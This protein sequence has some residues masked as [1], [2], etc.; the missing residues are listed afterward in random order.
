MNSLNNMSTNNMSA[1][2]LKIENAIK[3]NADSIDLSTLNLSEVPKELLKLKSLKRINLSGN[4][5]E[6]L[7][8]WFGEF[9]NVEVLDLK[10]CQLTQL[11]PELNR[12]K[13]LRALYLSRNNLIEL[14]KSLSDLDNL[15]LLFAKNN[16]I[17]HLPNWAFGIDT[18]DYDNNPVIDPPWK[19]THG[20]QKQF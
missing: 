7:P 4:P 2:L 20:V 11:F 17:T 15:R 5:L 8:D 1:Y 6:K 16:Q 9:E 18:F 10:D 3:N 14:P 12:L 13:S 19:Y